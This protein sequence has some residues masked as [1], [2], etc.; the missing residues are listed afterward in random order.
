ML[1]GSGGDLAGHAAQALLD[2]L[3]QAP[4]GAVAGEHGHIVD[5]EVAVAVGLGDL[6]V[7]DF[8]QPI[9]GGDGA[10]VGEDQ[11]AYGVGDGGVFLHAP[12]LDLEVLVHQR[13]VVEHGA[14]HVADLFALTAIEDVGL[15][16]VVVAGLD[17]HRLNAVLDILHGDRAV[18]DLGLEVCCDLQRKKVDHILIVLLV[19]GVKCLFDRHRDLADVKINDLVVAFYHLIHR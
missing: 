19:K 3:L 11:T 14:A 12:V 18:F 8:A 1:G 13:L 2:E 16:H 17:E 15:G 6:V 9:V 5:V 7:I 4:A 10:G